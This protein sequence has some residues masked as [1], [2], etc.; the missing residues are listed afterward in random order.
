MILVTGTVKDHFGN[1]GGL[2]SLGSEFAQQLGAVQV[3]TVVLIAFFYKAKHVDNI[4]EKISLLYYAENLLN[5]AYQAR[6]KY[7]FIRELANTQDWINCVNQAINLL[8]RLCEQFN[9]TSLRKI[10]F[11]LNMQGSD[12]SKRSNYAEAVKC[13]TLVYEIIFLLWGVDFDLEFAKSAINVAATYVRIGDNIPENKEDCYRN[14]LNY[15]DQAKKSAENTVETTGA[16][17]LGNI[18]DARMCVFYNL[19]DFQSAYESGEK[20]LEIWK[21]LSNEENIKWS[22]EQLNVLKPLL[23]KKDGSENE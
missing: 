10:I 18:Y 4:E 21:K 11:H 19:Q 9:E 23:S 20:S 22:E 2:G 6:K 8:K 1:I 15:Y 14:A 7:Q 13:Y 16:D 3:G 5:K 17:L 12:F